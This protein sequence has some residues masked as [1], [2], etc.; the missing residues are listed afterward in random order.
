MSELKTKPTDVSAESYIASVSNDTRRE[1]ASNLLKIMGE[2]TEAE[3]VMWGTSIV[4]FGTYHYT[5]TSGREGDWM[6]VGF[7]ARKDALVLYG[8]INDDDSS[9]NESLLEK[10]GPHKR[11]KG[12]LYIKSLSDV[13]VAALTQMIKNAFGAPS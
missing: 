9:A 5:Y 1:D 10:L 13:D 11:G 3:P 2:A 12:C 6:K 4:G 7:S 8:L